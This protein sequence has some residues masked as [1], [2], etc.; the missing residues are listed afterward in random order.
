[1]ESIV[2]SKYQDS[3]W[4]DYKYVIYFIENAI[5]RDENTVNLTKLVNYR[6]EKLKRF[7]MHYNYLCGNT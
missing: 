7:C 6:Y 3:L 1:M 4:S 2:N 5:M